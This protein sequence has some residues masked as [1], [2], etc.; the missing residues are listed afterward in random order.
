[1]NKKYLFGGVN[2]YA[3]K[4]TMQANHSRIQARRQAKMSLSGKFIVLFCLLLLPSRLSILPSGRAAAYTCRTETIRPDD[5]PPQA[6]DQNSRQNSDTVLTGLD[7]V[8]QEEFAPLAGKRVGLITNQSGITSEGRSNI[9]VLW[10]AAH[11]QTGKAPFTLVALFSPEHGLRGRVG[12]GA[13]VEDSHDR[14]TKLPIYSLYGGVQKP[15]RA[16][17]RGLDALVFDIQDIGS[18]SYTY[19]STLGFCMQAAAQNHLDFLV[20]DRPNPLGG[21]RVEGNI[22]SPEFRSFVGKYPVPYLHGLTV[23]ELARMLNDKKDGEKYLLHQVPCRLRVIPMQGWR[24]V[25]TWEETGL[26][27]VP[28]SPH[29]PFARTALYY[30]ATGTVGELPTLSIGI[31]TPLPFEYAGAPGLDAAAYA[32][33]L[34]RRALPGVRFVPANW[35]PGHGVY[36]GRRCTGV[37]IEFTDAP[38]CELTRLNFELMAAARQVKPSLNFFT[39]REMT[40]MFDLVNGTD[41]VRKEFVAGKSASALWSA[42]NKASESFRVRRKPFLLYH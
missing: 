15:T 10:R 13:Q 11:P 3:V 5:A 31:G 21:E 38:R 23:G 9:D 35:I 27:W 18:R 33:E 39:D 25:M 42:W 17:L 34:T 6:N 14:Q 40:R 41:R 37:H 16:M 1:M 22:P 29:I 2:V 20:L 19:I 12:A 36:K 4:C 7:V 32:A 26:P 30:A 28:T 24:R 8:I